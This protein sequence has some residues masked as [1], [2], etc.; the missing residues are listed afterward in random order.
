MV[1]SCL[2]CTKLVEDTCKPEECFNFSKFKLNQYMYKSV[3]NAIRTNTCSTC[4][5]RNTE[6][7][8]MRISLSD[9]IVDNTSDN[10]FCN[11][12]N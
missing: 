9:K 4:S 2:Y 6:V 1:P 12:Y 10:N 7:C 11:M 8:P 5:N 3:L